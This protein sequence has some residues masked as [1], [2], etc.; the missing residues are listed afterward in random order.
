MLIDTCLFIEHFRGN[1]AVSAFLSQ[2]A[3]SVRVSAI[4]DMELAQGVHNKQELQTYYKLLKILKAELIEIHEPIS[5]LAREWVRQYGL[6]HNL[7]LAD[8]LIAATAK[9]YEL[10]LY[11]ENVRDFRF[12][13]ITL[14]DL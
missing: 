2:H 1:A 14:G 8:A 10:T 4:T 5:A 12:L 13:D 3:G 6:S 11:T 7:N 9:H